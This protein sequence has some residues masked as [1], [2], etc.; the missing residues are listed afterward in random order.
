M[1]NAFNH[2]SAALRVCVDRVE[3][4]R[5]SGRVFSQRLTAPI[6]FTDFGGM[7]LQVEAVLDAQNFPQA[8]QRARSFAP[9]QVGTVPAADCLEDGM[10]PE[11]VQ[12][13]QGAVG[14]FLLYVITRRSATWQGFVDWLD[15]SP[16]QEY[17]SVLELLKLADQHVFHLADR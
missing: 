14:T 1:S 3:D 15:G 5:I 2:Y 11:T 9:R 8:F 4:G 10:D 16:R 17:G 7:L 12:A 6:T 13:A